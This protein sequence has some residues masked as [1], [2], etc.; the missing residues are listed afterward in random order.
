MQCLLMLC[1]VTGS[2]QQIE[3][4]DPTATGS[5]VLVGMQSRGEAGPPFA[6]QAIQ[7]AIHSKVT[8]I[9]KSVVIHT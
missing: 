1:A 6:V 9:A 8:T 4:G 7:E 5:D 3:R 2:K